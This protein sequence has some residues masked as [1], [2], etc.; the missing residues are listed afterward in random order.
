VA[1]THRGVQHFDLF[2]GPTWDA[3]DFWDW[4]PKRHSRWMV[5][6]QLIA[7]LCVCLAVPA[8]FVATLATLL[9]GLDRTFSGWR[10]F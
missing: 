8:C 5:A 2:D 10:F 1:Q 3:K 6:G 7:S 4:E 9:W